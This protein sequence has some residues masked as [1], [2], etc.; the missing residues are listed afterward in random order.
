[1]PKKNNA[2]LV[3]FDVLKFYNE[4]SEDSKKILD[5][6]LES[7]PQIQKLIQ[8]HWKKT[9]NIYTNDKLYNYYCNIFFD[10]LIEYSKKQSKRIIL[11]GIQIFVRLHP[12]KTVKMPL[13]I[14]GSSCFKSSKNKFKRD[15]IEAQ[16]KFSLYKYMHQL[17][18]YHIKQYFDINKFILY[19]RICDLNINFKG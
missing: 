11:E 10:F 19:Y 8:T 7:Y 5:I 16:N 14:V 3:S 9:D 2:I 13:I 15:F 18:L 6:F 12:S 17:Y 4:A 1:M